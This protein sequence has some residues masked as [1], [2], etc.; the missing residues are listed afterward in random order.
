MKVFT[1]KG[2]KSTSIGFGEGLLEAAEKNP[3]IVA[4]GADITHSVKVNAF[5]EKFPNRFFSMGIAEQNCVGVAAGFALTG[6]IP[7]FSTYAVFSALRTTDQIRVSV[8]FNKLHVVI[9]GAHAGI[10]VGPDGATHQALEDIA[11]MRVL[12]NMT[13]LSPCDAFQTKQ[14]TIAALTQLNSPVYI[15]YGR[16]AMPDFINASIPFEIGKGQLLKKGNDVSI[17]ATGHLTWE[18]LQAAYELE[19]ENI[20]ARVINIHTIKPI[21]Q[22][23]II[24]AAK[25]TGAIITAEEHQIYGGLGSAVAEVLAQ[26]CPVPIEFIGVKDSFGE[27]GK[28]LELMDKYGMTAKHIIDAVKRIRASRETEF[29][30]LG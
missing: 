27:S 24:Q 9:G 3:N 12:P 11:I 14:I 21:D 20:H 19:K 22:E 4:I 7:V 28:P 25:D 5:A 13:V 10:S 18:A 8:C 23:I 16:E 17:I 2:N 6:K 26:N 1:N 29:E 30:L 15:R